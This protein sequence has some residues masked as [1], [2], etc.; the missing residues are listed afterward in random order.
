ME[1]TSYEV[2]WLRRGKAVG[3]I[4]SFATLDEAVDAIVRL[5]KDG[6]AERLEILE[7]HRKPYFVWK[8]PGRP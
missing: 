7:V 2:R 8:E 3:E 6:I 4:L 5:A 1:Y